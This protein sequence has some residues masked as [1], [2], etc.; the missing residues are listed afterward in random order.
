MGTKTSYLELHEIISSSLTFCICDK[1]PFSAHIAIGSIEIDQLQGSCSQL[2]C[3]S[4]HS[5][6]FPQGR[7]AKRLAFSAMSK[8]CQP[9]VMHA[10]RFG[11]QIDHVWPEKAG[12]KQ[13]NKQW[14]LSEA[15]CWWTLASNRKQLASNGLHQGSTDLSAE[16]ECLGGGNVINQGLMQHE[17][18]WK[19]DS[20]LPVMS[21]TDMDDEANKITAR[22]ATWTW[23][24]DRAEFFSHDQLSNLEWF[25]LDAPDQQTNRIVNQSQPADDGSNE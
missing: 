11:T 17:E 4:K 21:S 13:A 10:T 20:W 14:F 16:Q 15:S 23:M 25:S 8:S 7:T 5:F 1:P 18:E 24:K 12:W 22:S 9:F 6:C 2:I 3:K 19:E